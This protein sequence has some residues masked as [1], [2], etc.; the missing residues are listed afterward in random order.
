MSAG[1]ATNVSRRMGLVRHENTRPELALRKALSAR[2]L[3]YRLHKREL[4]GTPDIVF[5]A[6]KFAV[7]VHGCFWHRHAA[8][9]KSTMPRT[10]IAFWTDK[11]EK[12]IDRDERN[13][14]ALERQG[15]KIHLVWECE[16]T[17]DV[18]RC[19]DRILELVTFGR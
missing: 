5:V 11:F 4:A 9:R 12:N 8:C 15:W 3:R 2:R 14:A 6:A 19:A 16:I 18:D 1:T 10:N 17:D 7:F 13:Y